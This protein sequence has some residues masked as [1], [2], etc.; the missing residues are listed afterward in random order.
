MPQ[1]NGAA[2]DMDAEPFTCERTGD[3]GIEESMCFN[4]EDIY[5]QFRDTSVPF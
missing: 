2:L 5:Y 3:E 1:S 4:V